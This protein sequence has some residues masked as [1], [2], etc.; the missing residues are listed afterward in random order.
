MTDEAGAS[1]LRPL[2][3]SSSRRIRW[4]LMLLFILVGLCAA[5]AHFADSL[6]EF[7]ETP[8]DG[9]AGST[10]GL[11]PQDR[12]FLSEMQKTQQK[13]S[14]DLA[15]LNRRLDAQRGNLK[16]ILD[17]LTALTSQIASLQDAM[18]ASSAPTPANALSTPVKRSIGRSKSQG[19]VLVG[20]APVIAGPKPAEH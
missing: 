9:Q 2:L 10:M 7:V 3:H 5:A 17:Q 19:P 18:P 6:A 1:D 13:A 16:A 11:S 14:D 4:G 20:G 12:S 8:A 15:E